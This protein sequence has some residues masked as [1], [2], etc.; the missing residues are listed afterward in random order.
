MLK[1]FFIILVFFSSLYSYSTDTIIFKSVYLPKSDTVLV[2]TPESKTQTDSA[3][4][5]VY[6]LHGYGG[7][8]KSFSNF[9]DLQKI[10]NEYQFIIVCPD[11]LFESWYIDSP[12]QKYPQFESFFVKELYP[13][14]NRKYHADTSHIFISGYSMGGHGSLYLFLRHPSLFKAAASSSGVLDLNYSSLKLTSLSKIIGDYE[15]NKEIFNQYSAIN[16]LDSIKFSDKE[17]FVDCGL[18]DHL[19]KSNDL[20]AKECE[21]RWIQIHYMI[22]D[23]RHNAGYWKKSFPWHFYFFS[24]LK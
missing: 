13:E 21:K 17:I 3:Y 10:S 24:T 7:D 2:F 19:L 1:I 12:K 11:G 18:K 22:S 9:L 8:Y 5:I 6:L 16:L 20:F 15:L 4:S 23:G 14:I